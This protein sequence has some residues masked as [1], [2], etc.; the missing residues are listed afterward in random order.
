MDED[1]EMDAEETTTTTITKIT[2]D[3]TTETT[4]NKT[5]RQSCATD[6]EDGETTPLG[7]VPY[8][9]ETSSSW[10]NKWHHRQ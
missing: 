3:G 2:K 6:V 9:Q 4:V 10:K 1:A 8:Q 7:I 5:K